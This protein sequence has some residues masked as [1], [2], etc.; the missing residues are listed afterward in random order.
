MIRPEL[1]M[2]A[3]GAD[4]TAFWM[5]SCA[6]TAVAPALTWK[7]L[8]PLVRPFPLMMVLRGPSPMKTTSSVSA[9]RGVFRI[10]GSA[11]L[12][13][14]VSV[15]RRTL[16]WTTASRREPGPSSPDWVTT[17]DSA[18]HRPR[19]RP[20]INKVKTLLKPFIF[21]WGLEISLLFAA[22]GRAEPSKKITCL[23]NLD[24]IYQFK[25]GCWC[26]LSAIKIIRGG[27]SV[28]FKQLH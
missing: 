18:T 11:T 12:K 5:V 6:K 10:T 27:S 7:R 24:R 3:P 17:N 23:T 14:I 26:A 19:A 16:A 25:W 13:R 1:W 2:A 15:P 9:G 28:V 8:E 21:H 20:Q 22:E 4:E